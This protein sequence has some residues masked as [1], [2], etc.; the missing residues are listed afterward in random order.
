MTCK[1]FM[2]LEIT[3]NLNT[4]PSITIE[5][6]K[7][8]FA[9]W[10]STRVGKQRIPQQ[11]WQMAVALLDTHSTSTVSNV[12]K[13]DYGQL[14]QRAVALNVKTHHLSSQSF[15]E[16]KPQ[17]LSASISKLPLQPNT[18]SQPEFHCTILIERI[19]GSR[20]TITLPT[21]SA[22]LSS[23]CANLLKV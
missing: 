21:H 22:L 17:Q 1:Y 12:L 14:K 7:A 10:R 18:G 8:E 11:L 15:L 2:F 23:L 19:D 13:L 9:S 16:V 4:K 6:V 5:Q 20:V 3:V